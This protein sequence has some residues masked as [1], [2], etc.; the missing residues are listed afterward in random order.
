LAEPERKPQPEL[1]A[2]LK[3]LGGFPEPFLT[4]SDRHARRWRNAYGTTL[5]RED[6]GTLQSLKD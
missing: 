1:H 4:G 3:K 2:G 5:V 6:V